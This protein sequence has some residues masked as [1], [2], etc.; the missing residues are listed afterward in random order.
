MVRTVGAFWEGLDR[1]TEEAAAA[2]GASPCRVFG[3][4]TL[5]ALL[6]AIAS[7]ASVVFL[8]CSTS[9]GIVLTLGGLRYANVETEI[10]Q[11]TTQFLDLQAAAALSVLQIV[12]VTGL[13]L[14]AHRA[15]RNA[16]ALSRGGR[17]RSAPAA[18]R[19]ARRS[20][21][22]RVVVGLLLAPLISL[23]VALAAHR[24][25]L[26]PGQLP[27]AADHRRATT[28][29]WSPATERAAQLAADRGR[30]RPSFALLLGAAR[31]VLVSRPPRS[32]LERRASGASTRCSC[33]RSGSPR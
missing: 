9:F 24:R 16:P 28:R 21:G 26:G 15:R 2:L 18:P 10:Y 11:L 33:C 7:A 32:R 20:A 30:R 19:P 3:T 1:R 17:A 12:V 31:R 23:L 22:P 29:C 27:G 6:P 4:V 5:P 14:L 25:R 13:L 8:F